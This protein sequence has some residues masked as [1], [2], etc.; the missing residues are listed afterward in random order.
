MHYLESAPSLRFAQLIKCFWSL[1]YQNCGVGEPEPIVPDG[2]IEIVFNL[3]DRFRRFIGNECGTQPASL[4]AGQMKQCVLIA[5]TGDVRLF[6]I[7][8]QSH[9][10]VP[11]FRFD[12]SE[13]A[14]R[15]VPL[16]ELACKVGQD[17]IRACTFD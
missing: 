3:A 14:N 9:G 6:G 11:F 8:F 1:E 15:I 16:C 13:L 7:R 10:A 5:P 2:C 4:V 17:N 12:L